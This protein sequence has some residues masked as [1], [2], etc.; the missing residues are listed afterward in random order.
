MTI[1]PTNSMT[2]KFVQKL[3]THGIHYK[4]KPG[5]ELTLPGGQLPD[6]PTLTKE[7]WRVSKVTRGS[8]AY[9]YILCVIAV[10]TK[11][12]VYLGGICGEKSTLR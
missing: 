4:A 7:F 11:T 9:L 3:R 2:L 5:P 8:K 1:F 10:I 12:F 6:L